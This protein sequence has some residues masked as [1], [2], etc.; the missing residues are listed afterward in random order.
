MFFSFAL[1]GFDIC[2]YF[3]FICTDDTKYCNHG[4]DL[5]L[6]CDTGA[7]QMI[8][9]QVDGPHEFRVCSMQVVSGCP[10]LLLQL[11]LIHFLRTVDRFMSFLFCSRLFQIISGCFLQIVSSHFLLAAGR[12]LLV[13]GRFPSFQVVSR[14]S[15][16]AIS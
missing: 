7:L 1:L 10:L 6:R 13:V 8:I 12:F 15:K 3:P 14:F 2:F 16:Y 4:N 11:I 5:L 9:F